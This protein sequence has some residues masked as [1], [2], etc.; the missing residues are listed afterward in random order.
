MVQVNSEWGDGV[1][2]MRKHGYINSE[3]RR[4]ISSSATQW[5]STKIELIEITATSNQNQHKG[6]SFR[7]WILTAVLW[8]LCTSSKR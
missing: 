2:E 3:T 1:K 6:D 8:V 7:R 5:Y 4:V